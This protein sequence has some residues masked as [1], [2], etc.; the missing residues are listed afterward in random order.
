MKRKHISI[1]IVVLITLLASACGG[2]KINRYEAQ[3]LVLF[4]TATTVIGFAET[5]EA[6]GEM[7][8]LVYDELETYHQLYDIYNDYDGINNMKTINENA[9]ISPVVVDRKIIDLILF[10]EEA[11]EKTGGKVNIAFGSVLKIWHDYREQ[12][13]DDPL[14][15]KLPTMEELQ[16]AALH[17]DIEKIIIDEAA[18]T[19]FLPDPDMRL[20]VGGIAK[21]YA[22][23]RVSDTL[24]TS[25][26]PDFLISVGGNVRAN[27][28]RGNDRSL[29]K[30]GIQNPDID[31]GK[32]DLFTAS[33]TDL[34]LVTSGD[35][36]RYYTVDGERYHHIIDP[37][38]LMPARYF[39]AVTIITEDSGMADALST[40]VFNMSFE[41]GIALVDSFE[42]T[43][44]LWVFHDGTQKES[45]RF[46]AM[47]GIQ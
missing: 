21:G 27:G 24:V 41:D 19:V 37:E 34:S 20:D 40:A 25:G 23:E 2:P 4:D 3:F 46:K 31:N 11:Y 36:I 42:K 12:G 26:Y 22:A 38:T 13:I 16:S 30:V 17:T 45:Q 35:Y 18:S 15:A 14:G 47:I 10:S 7:A 32:G 6:F 1:L 44:A 33:L 8:N 5:E 28:R 9:G 39:A 43:E 29:W